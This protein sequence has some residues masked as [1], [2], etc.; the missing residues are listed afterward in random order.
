M[1]VCLAPTP[2]STFVLLCI[3]DAFTALAS[4]A[5]ASVSVSAECTCSRFGYPLPLLV[6]S[7]VHLFAPH[8]APL[9][10]ACLVRCLLL[11]NMQADFFSTYHPP[12]PAPVV[13]FLCVYFAARRVS[14]EVDADYNVDVD[15]CRRCAKYDKY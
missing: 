5:S 7:F 2:P 9:H 8:A 3:P 11:V 14:T 13:L 4:V 10:A 12:P 1:S 6:Y 15:G